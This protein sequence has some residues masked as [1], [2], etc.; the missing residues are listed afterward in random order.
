MEC[1]Y[2]SGN[3]EKIIDGILSTAQ[4]VY[5]IEGVKS[6]VIIPMHSEKMPYFISCCQLYL[7][8]DAYMRKKIETVLDITYIIYGSEISALIYGSDYYMRTISIERNNHVYGD[9]LVF[10]GSSFNDLLNINIPS[11]GSIRWQIYEGKFEGMIKR[12]DVVEYVN[13]II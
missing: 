3:E 12:D 1:V 2:F 11:D 7:D 13:S 10:Y 8:D 4:N 5:G 6:G 9:Q